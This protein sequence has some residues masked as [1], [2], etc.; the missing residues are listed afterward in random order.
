MEKKGDE[1]KIDFDLI[2]QVNGFEIEEES[3]VAKETFLKEL[4]LFRND[5]YENHFLHNYYSK[6]I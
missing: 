5:E 4:K 1:E 6:G 2:E 3:V